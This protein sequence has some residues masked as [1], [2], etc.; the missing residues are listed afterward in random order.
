MTTI[1]DRS[2]ESPPAAR[3]RVLV[4][5]DHELVRDGLRMAFEG[6][7]VEIVVEAV[8]GQQAFEELQRHRPEVALI[9]INMPRADGF[10]FLA[11]MRDAGIS[12]P[13]IMHSVLDGSEILRRCRQLGA[14]GFVLKGS[15]RELLLAAVRAAWAGAECW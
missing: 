3:I 12:L 13:V 9:D 1:S 2:I 4:A 11:L 8:D 14:R 10:T 15:D 5:D 6:T 7:D